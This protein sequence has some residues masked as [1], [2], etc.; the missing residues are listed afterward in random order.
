MCCVL[1]ARL[2]AQST[3]T[4]RVTS[5]DEGVPIPAATLLLIKS[6]LQGQSDDQGRF[7]FPN[8]ALPDS[9]K[10]S[11]VG[12]ITQIIPVDAKS[13][14]LQIQLQRDATALGEVIVQ[15]GY[16]SIPKER[17]TGS[18]EVLD[19]KKLNLKS[20][21]YLLNRLD[22]ISTSINFDRR[23][24][25]SG[26]GP[27]SA[28]ALTIRGIST[29]TSTAKAPLIVLNNFIYDGNISN[30]NPNDVES[31]TI[32]KDAAAASIWGARAANGVIVISTK[33]GKY[34]SKTNISLTTN[35][36]WIPK[37]DLFKFTRMTSA[38][39][40]EV[41]RMLFD[42]GF[43]NADISN[44][45]NYPALSPVV[46]ILAR[47]RPGDISTSEA[48]Q[49]IDGYTQ[50][51][52][53][54]DFLQYIY[55][56][57][58]QQQYSLRVAGGGTTARYSLSAGLD[59]TPGSLVGNRSRRTTLRWEGGI[60]P[61]NNLEVNTTVLYAGINA[62]ENAIGEYG[63]SAYNYRMTVKELYPYALL[64][65]N[66]GNPLVLERYYRPGYV[67]TAGAGKL[68]NWQ[69]KPLEEINLRDNNSKSDDLLL[70][71]SASYKI[72]PWLRIQASYQ[73]QQA[74]I[75]SRNIN[76]QESFMARDLINRFTQISGNN[77]LYRVPKGGILDQSLIRQSSQNGKAQFTFNRQISKYHQINGLAGL[78][79]R[80]NRYEQNGTRT[81]GFSEETLTF[82]P[83]DYATTFPLYGSFGIGQIPNSQSFER[84]VDRFVSYY[85][86]ISY[87]YKDRYI[88]TGS[89]RKDASNVFGVAAN[90]RWKPLW[91]VG[92]RWKVDKE[93]FFRSSVVRQLAL[94][95][96]FGYQG[97]GNNAISPLTTL[98]ISANGNTLINQPTA[99]IATPANPDLSWEQ[100][101][102]TNIGMD[103]ALSNGLTVALDGYMKNSNNL[104]LG[105]R[106]DLTTGLSTVL[107]N[108][109]SIKT[110]GLELTVSKTTRWGSLS[111]SK[112]L[113]VSY[114]DNKVMDYVIADQSRSV[115]G[116]VS[117]GGLT[118][119]P[120]RGNSPYSVYSYPSAGLDPQTGDPRGY[121]GGIV[122]KDY[123]AMMRQAL[124]TSNIIRHG[125]A[126]PTVF[127]SFNN[128][129][130]YKGF[131]L[132]VGISFKAGYYFR[133]NSIN[134][135]NL[136]SRGSMHGD[137][138][139]RW[140]APGDEVQTSIPSLVYPNV[141]GRDQFYEGT[142]GNVQ[143][144]DHIRLQFMKVGYT[145]D[146]VSKHFK[147]MQLFAFVSNLGILWSANKL[148]LD[149]DYD[150]NLQ[151]YPPLKNYSLGLNINF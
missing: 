38:E 137:F 44:H 60:T 88:L 134:Y 5:K 70:S 151:R 30:I 20:G 34:N 125:S 132:T 99:T 42:K 92:G 13:L 74:S 109:A 29:L 22:G 33:T 129:F 40:I 77:I 12:Y 35:F 50:K 37:P 6:T 49:L 96:T 82:I 84:R 127:G 97:N 143:K 126:L 1:A 27:I 131:F 47:Q 9:L 89:A 59:E 101:S 65:D 133:K 63:T 124:D 146:N 141:S 10:V 28:D 41:E 16:E 61:I 148:G 76:S 111:W 108:S 147:S 119:Y 18:F 91:S 4:G 104:I 103:L 87:T 110:K 43:Y 58:L 72:T 149:P 31:I 128:S 95:G 83:V 98:T 69:Y 25:T 144:G 122:S 81:Y 150:L 15:T 120:I 116:F 23:Q 46:E 100:T 2:T 73:F 67:D 130:S 24:S 21:P 48:D 114:V 94:R 57:A 45:T 90:N 139:N 85:G 86:N 112:D 3:L 55:Q 113:L 19:E 123:N 32:L 121:L 102:Q 54:N 145:L 7:S 107:K 66:N 26:E 36:A 78:E 64:A 39:F 136:F 80:D 105:A 142:E 75:N 118:I 140:Q 71:A 14:A 53:R 138:K 52:V 135:N 68:L 51:D 8:V 93:P 79:I 56:T 17:A 117:S 11:S 62:Q 106:M 115:S